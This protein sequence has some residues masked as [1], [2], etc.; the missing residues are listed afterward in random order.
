[1]PL[2]KKSQGIMPN[3]YLYSTVGNL[4]NTYTLSLSAVTNSS[5]SQSMANLK[6]DKGNY[7]ANKGWLLAKI[8]SGIQNGKVGP[9]D[10]GASDGRQ[11]AANIVG[12][13]DTFA[14]LEDGDKDVGV[15]YVGTVTKE[16][17]YVEGTKGNPSDTIKGY[18]RTATLD[19]LFK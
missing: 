14:N 6:D 5:V 19:I 13:L 16:N 7:Y 17:V 10:S 4:F 1:M 15:L 3:E 11:T 9:Y 18:L 12:F 8:T 2:F